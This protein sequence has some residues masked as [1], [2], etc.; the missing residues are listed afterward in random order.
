MEPQFQV[1]GTKK[2]LHSSNPNKKPNKKSKRKKKSKKEKSKKRLKKELEMCNSELHS[3]K[4]PGGVITQIDLTSNSQK[5]KIELNFLMLI[6]IKNSQFQ[7]QIV[8]ELIMEK[9]LYLFL[10]QH[11]YQDLKKILI[12]S[13][14]KQTIHLYQ[15]CLMLQHPN[16]SPPIKSCH[17]HPIIYQSSPRSKPFLCCATYA[18]PKI[19]P[20]YPGFR[21]FTIIAYSK[22]KN[23]KSL[24]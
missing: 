11:S 3:Y 8:I 10:I 7:E 1:I 4:F 14:P 18:T 12:H 23:R 13:H 2:K 9:D 24:I 16:Q 5:K 22:E 21:I 17:H 6:L 20:Y 19:N 15:V